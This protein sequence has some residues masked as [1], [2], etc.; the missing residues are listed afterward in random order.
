[1][2]E[3]DKLIFTDVS[4]SSPFRTLKTLARA[5]AGLSPTAPKSRLPNYSKL[6]RLLYL[7]LD[8]EFQLQFLSRAS[9]ITVYRLAMESSIVKAPGNNAP[10]SRG[11]KGEPNDGGKVHRRTKTGC[12]SKKDQ[13]SYYFFYMKKNNSQSIC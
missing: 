1:M 9:L 3:T 5:A 10:R 7:D 13:V 11:A 12:L 6:S 2:N 4:R 8:D